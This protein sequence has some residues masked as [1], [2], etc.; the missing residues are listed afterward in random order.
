MK[1]KI[2]ITGDTHGDIKR[3]SSKKFPEGKELN[4]ND[5]VI[6]LGDWG[7][8]WKNNKD[9][10]EIY[11]MNWIIE[12]PWTTIVILGNH[13]NW[14]RIEKLPETTFKGA[15]CWEY[16]HTKN[17]ELGSV[18]FPKPGEIF[19]INNKKFLCL[20]KATSNDKHLRTEYIDWWSNEVYSYK[21]TEDI[22]NNLDKVNWKVDYVL[23]HTCPQSVAYQFY[24]GMPNHC[25][26]SQFMDYIDERLEFKEFHC[27]HFHNERKFQREYCNEIYQCHY[28]ETKELGE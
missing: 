6:Q 22:L 25:Q 11:W 4:K 1:S 13:E 15:K 26:V 27:G 2:F 12:K 7:V 5:I 20:P 23:G 24:D 3:F 21:D 9:S 18:Y 10:E 28:K 16:K 14:D 17:S 19:N 8:I